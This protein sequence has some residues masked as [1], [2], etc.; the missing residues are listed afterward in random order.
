TQHSSRAGQFFSRLLVPRDEVPRAIKEVL[1]SYRAKK[2]PFTRQTAVLVQ[3][4]APAD[5]SGVLFTRSP[6]NALLAH[7]EFT[8]GHAD[9]LVAGREQPQEC[10]FSRVTGHSRP[11]HRQCQHMLQAVFFAGMQIEELLGNPQDIEWTFDARRQRLYV[12][13][14]R[15]ITRFLYSQ[16]VQEEQDKIARLVT[17][18]AESAARRKWEIHPLHEV[19][20]QPGTFTLSLM[21]RLYSLQGSL[22][23]AYRQ[24]H[25]YRQDLPSP[26][27]SLFFHRLFLEH[28]GAFCF[29]GPRF[30]HWLSLQWHAFALRCRP[31]RYFQPLRQ[32]LEAMRSAPFPACPA[33]A[34][35]PMQA[36]LLLDQL[37]AFVHTVYPLAFKASL[38]SLLA[39]G[40][41][42]PRPVPTL[43]GTLAQDLHTLA[44]RRTLKDFMAKWGY[45]SF[46][47][48]DLAAP[49]FHEAPK[50]ALAYA[51]RFRDY[52]AVS[53]AD[54]AGPLD[55]LSESIRLKEE[56]KDFAIQWL[57]R[58][59]PWF[60]ALGRRLHLQPCA[61]VFWLS[62]DDLRL[63]AEQPGKVNVAQ[64]IAR[65][66]KCAEIFWKL[67]LPD[68]LTLEDSFFVDE[69]QLLSRPAAAA[70]RLPD[71]AGRP[72]S[73]RKPLSGTIA[74][75]SEERAR[76]PVF[77]KGKI[78]VTPFLQPELV[79]LYGSVLGIITERGGTLSHAA[80]VAREQ[81]VPVYQVP[82]A[83]TLLSD[84][85]FVRLE[86]TGDLY[87]ET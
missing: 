35:L 11:W 85:A 70:R 61:D 1:Q 5:F 12:V 13:Q 28:P 64:S 10:F 40:A 2:I 65:Q 59:R 18:G 54:N 51:R 68:V 30:L 42:Q 52:P 37:H 20:P 8:A 71:L 34:P 80:I 45:R 46:N 43:A 26:A 67:P 57:R 17:E 6:K 7:I 87:V 9:K 58:R 4:M 33:K 56:T 27:P 60:L 25:I 86:A 69:F 82:H 49:S 39:H 44:M 22:G 48:Y 32:Q 19:V 63:L 29:L 78:L 50:Q 41:S 81:G 73:V 14:A 21:Q 72:L 24:L 23:A 75:Y 62:W 79:G 15:P 16:E 76:H 66:K 3:A 36:R 47:D 74:V 38:L 53:M 31:A 84:Q 77:Y 83:C 55:V